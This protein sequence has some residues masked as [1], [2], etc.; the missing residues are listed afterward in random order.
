MLRQRRSFGH[1]CGVSFGCLGWK[2]C[3]LR[4]VVS[5]WGMMDESGRVAFE[6]QSKTWVMDAPSPG[7]RDSR[8]E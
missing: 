8:V 7:S 2:F 6:S 3:G 1:L 4:G 5:F